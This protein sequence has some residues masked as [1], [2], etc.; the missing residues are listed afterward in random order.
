MPWLRQEDRT[1]LKDRGQ[2]DAV[3]DVGDPEALD[4]R[5]F[6]VDDGL[7]PPVT[8]QHRPASVRTQ[9]TANARPKS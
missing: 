7:P 5:V 6:I 1:W 9:D 8:T 4:L 3:A 2:R